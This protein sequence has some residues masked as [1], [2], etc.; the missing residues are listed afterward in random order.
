[1]APISLPSRLSLPSLPSR[2]SLLSLPSR[3]SLL[4]LLFLLCCRPAQA[5]LSKTAHSTHNTAHNTAH[6]LCSWQSRGIDASTSTYAS[7]SSYTPT[8]RSALYASPTISSV[9]KSIAENKRAGHEYEWEDKI[10][11]GVKLVGTEVKACRTGNVILSDGHVQIMGGE[12]WL[13]SVH[14][15]EFHGCGPLFQHEVKRNRKL[16][17]KRKEVGVGY[18]I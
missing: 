12:L 3:L 18:S 7:A 10:E 8:S 16:L 11:A 4:S 13:C 1:M 5:L 17:V 9:S 15:A 6:S 2:L 14:I